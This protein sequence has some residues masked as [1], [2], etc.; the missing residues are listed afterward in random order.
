MQA[1][2]VRKIPRTPTIQ[3]WSDILTLAEHLDHGVYCIPVSV[4]IR[5]WVPCCTRQLEVG[6]RNRLHIRRH[7]LYPD[8]TVHGGNVSSKILSNTSP[9]ILT[10][11]RMYDRHMKPIPEAPQGGLANRISILVGVTGMKMAKYRPSWTES[12]LSP[13]NVIWRPQILGILVFEV[14]QP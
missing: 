7:C 14:S 13:I 6:V 4:S 8:R 2:K 1:R 12:I 10:P 5:V 11:H 9:T 3:N